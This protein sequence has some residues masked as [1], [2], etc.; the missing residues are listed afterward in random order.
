MPGF[1]V[2]GTTFTTFR[3][4]HTA[5]GGFD[6]AEEV[7]TGGCS[8]SAVSYEA[9]GALRPV[10]YCHCRQCRRQSGHFVAATAIPDESLKVTGE[11]NLTWYR[12]S[13]RARRGFCRI[14]GSGLFWKHDDLSQTSIFAG[15]LDNPSGLAA[16]HHIHVKNK[17]S[18][19][20]IDDG[21]PQQAGWDG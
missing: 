6:M 3:F 8:C 12:S 2:A 13:D 4:K 11:R 9:R 10:I 18:Y 17:G 16:S 14:C 5:A 20:A 15:S 21:L 19:Y 7:H 1:F